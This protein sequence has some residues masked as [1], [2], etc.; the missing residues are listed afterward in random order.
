MW[1]ENVLRILEICFSV[2]PNDQLVTVDQ[3][4]L[5]T[6]KNTFTGGIKKHNTFSTGM[7]KGSIESDLPASSF[8]SPNL[9]LNLGSNLTPTPNGGEKVPNLL[10][11]LYIK[12]EEMEADKF[13]EIR[14]MDF[15]I[16][17]IKQVV[18]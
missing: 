7:K 13:K 1:N 8:Q 17:A 6:R 2:D 10:E 15:E 12:R 9:N 11:S 14:N 3:E 5:P 4:P 16:Y 18:E